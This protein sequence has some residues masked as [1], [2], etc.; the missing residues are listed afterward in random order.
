MFY[1]SAEC[2]LFPLTEEDPICDFDCGREGNNADLT[3]FFC[4]DALDYQKQL[5][6]Q[7]LFFR[8]KD[9]GKIACAFT[10]SNDSIKVDDLPNN[11]K[12]KIGENIPYIKRK[13]SY[14]ATL[15]GRFGVSVELRKK[16]I[17]SAVMDFIK[18]ICIT[19]DAHKCRFLI[20]DAYNTGEAIGFYSKNDFQ[21]VFS[22][23]QQEKD[24]YEKDN[25]EPLKTRFMYYDL[26]PW[27][28]KLNEEDIPLLQ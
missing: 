28:N 20:V 4:N 18:T 6:G 11:R 25:Q 15:I 1:L 23:E 19:E 17:G 10:L 2:D 16:H 7:T 8:L 21:F 24:Y 3:D 13:R 22:T 14:P 27:V 12:K 9:N 5:L 26:L